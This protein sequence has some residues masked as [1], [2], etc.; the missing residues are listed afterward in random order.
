MI[1]Y[2][3]EQVGLLVNQ[4]KDLGI[5]ENT[6]IIFSSDNG[7][8]YNGGTDSPW[9][10]SGGPFKSQYGWGKGYTHEG[11]MR[12]PMIAAWPNI[13]KASQESNHISA[14]WDVLPTLCDIAGVEIPD[15]A[16]GVSFLPELMGKSQKKSK[17]LYWEFPE[18]GGQQAVRMGKWKAIRKE[19]QKGNLKTE[20]YNLEEDIK[21]LNDVAGQNS[22][23]I[24]KIEK[25]MVKE[26]SR[27]EHIIFR[28]EAL[29]D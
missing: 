9:F 1:S 7:P 28:M 26:H 27:S 14:F 21:E 5:Y 3:D 29:E 8:T 10:D 20:L 15:Y 24:K 6:L 22:N 19:I 13:I 17:Y 4:L 25:I 2:L 18:Y 23:I 11:G 16:D 12:V